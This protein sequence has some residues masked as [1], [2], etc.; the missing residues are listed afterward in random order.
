MKIIKI[1]MENFKKIRA[2]TCELNGGNLVVHGKPDEGKTTAVSA[3]WNVLESKQ[4][5]LRHGAEKG[6]VRVTIGEPGNEYQIIAE[7][8]FTKKTSSIAIKNSKGEKVEKKIVNDLVDV[9]SDDPLKML[10]LKGRALTDFIMKSIILP[11]G[12]S[13]EVSDT[14]RAA[15]VEERLEAG[16]ELKYSENLLGEEPENVET[17]DIDA[18]KAKLDNLEYYIK[19]GESKKSEIL[20]LGQKIGLRKQR[21]DE[22]KIEL[23]RLEQECVQSEKCREQVNINLDSARSRFKAEG[24]LEIENY[25]EQYKNA[26]EINVKAGLYKKWSESLDMLGKKRL[27]HSNLDDE[28]K[29][30]DAEKKKA[31]DS[32]ICPVKNLSIDD[33]KVYFEGSLLENCGTE[34][35]MFVSASLVASQMD[36]VKVMRIDRAES[37]GKDG[38]A[39]LI[40]I[41]NN[42]GVQVCMSRVSDEEQADG[43]IRIV[44]G[45]YEK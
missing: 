27:T 35:Q 28:I 24:G 37:M 10:D 25:R 32:A 20:I 6:F 1:D 31:L 34:K 33:G 14:A 21:I 16:R 26:I 17:V 7:R 36:G 45:V 30:I 38:R 43:E 29:K 18:V 11:D 5:I 8:R 2:F 40:D 44:N 41:C 12:F 4:D 13:I 23:E 39:K 3:L 42:L 19:S 22:I 9:I 15:K